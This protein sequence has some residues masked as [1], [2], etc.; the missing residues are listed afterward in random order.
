MKA[1]KP[2]DVGERPEQLSM[3]QTHW[4]RLTTMANKTEKSPSWLSVVE[5]LE[6]AW[7]HDISVQYQ[8][9]YKLNICFRLVTCYEALEQINFLFSVKWLLG[10][11]IFFFWIGMNLRLRGLL[12]LFVWR[13]LSTGIFYIKEERER[14]RKSDK[15]K[16]EEIN[17]AKKY[18]D[19]GFA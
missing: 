18:L 11:F 14:E 16:E 10:I 7:R 13:L 8:R 15:E 5:M 6:S 3:R 2:F 12:C 9:R 4:F 1:L 17:R 19:L